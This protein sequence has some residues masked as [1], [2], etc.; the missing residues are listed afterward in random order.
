MTEQLTK[1][2]P[3]AGLEGCQVSFRHHKSL[4]VRLG[5]FDGEEKMRDHHSALCF[6]V[7]FMLACSAMCNSLQPYR[8]ARQVPLSMGCSRQETGVGC[9]LQGIF[10]TQSLSLPLLHLLHWQAGSLPPAPPEK[11]HVSVNLAI[12]D[13]AY[14]WINRSHFTSTTRPTI[15]SKKTQEIWGIE[16]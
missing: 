6:S 2:S 1:P 15:G 5:M 14:K 16:C 10:L 3:A 11:P 12:L 9:H 13:A 4:G 8:L 7:L